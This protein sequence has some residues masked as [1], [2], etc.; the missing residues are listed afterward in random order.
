VFA[1]TILVDLDVWVCLAPTHGGGLLEI[2]LQ[3]RVFQTVSVRLKNTVWD[4][5]L[6]F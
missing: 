3:I 2:S 1:R 5:T 6:W 4:G